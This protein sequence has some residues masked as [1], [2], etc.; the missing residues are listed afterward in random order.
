MFLSPFLR[1]S[2]VMMIMVASQETLGAKLDPLKL[3]YDK[4]ATAW[5]EGLPIGNGRLGAM[6]FGQGVRPS[7]IQNCPG[8]LATSSPSSPV[9]VCS[10]QCREAATIRSVRIEGGGGESP[11]KLL[12]SLSRG[13]GCQ[14]LG[15]LR[16]SG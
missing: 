15:M 1:L 11:T 9:G 13:R 5:V 2:V 6:V 7:R 16:K 3:R 14:K 10:D 8:P 12:Q 4:P